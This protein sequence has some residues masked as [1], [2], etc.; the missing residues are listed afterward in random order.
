VRESVREIRRLLKQGRNGRYQLNEYVAFLKNNE[1]VDVTIEEV[2]PGVDASFARRLNYAQLCKVLGKN[3]QAYVVYRRLLKERPRSTEAYVGWVLLASEEDSIKRMLMKDE[4]GKVDFQTLSILC[5]QMNTE[6]E[7]NVDTSLRMMSLLT[8]F[9]KQLEPNESKNVNLSWANYF[10]LRRIKDTSFQDYSLASL[11]GGLD[12]RKLSDKNAEKTA[13]RDRIA[14]HLFISMIR[15]AQ[16]AEQ[17]F[18]LL[19]SSK[20]RLKITEE[21]LR[22]FAKMAAQK[23]FQTDALA[24]HSTHKDQLWHRTGLYEAYGASGPRHSVGPIDYLTSSSLKA[25]SDALDEE[26]L[27]KIE[28]Y[29]PEKFKRMT[30]VKYLNN[31][32]EKEALV[33]FEKWKKSL[34]E[35]VTERQVA[36]HHLMEALILSHP[37]NTAWT[38]ELQKLFVAEDNRNSSSW[39]SIGAKW[40]NWLMLTQGSDVCEDYLEQLLIN[41]LA[42]KEKWPI[43][44]Q[45]GNR[46]LPS[47][48]RQ[49]SYRVQ[50]L[51]DILFADPLV[52]NTAAFKIIDNNLIEVFSNMNSPMRA[53]WRSSHQSPENFIKWLIKNEIIKKRTKGEAFSAGRVFFVW[54][55]CRQVR[56]KDSKMKEAAVKLLR[57]EKSFDPMLAQIMAA[58]FLDSTKGREIIA[59]TIAANP[60]DFAALKVYSKSKTQVMLRDWFPD[61]TADTSTSGAESYLK[62]FRKDSLE[63][64]KLKTAAWMKDGIVNAG[65]S[66]DGS[67][68]IP[69]VLEIIEDDPHKAVTLWTK[70]LSDLKKEESILAGSSFSRPGSS[71]LLHRWHNRLARDISSGRKTKIQPIKQIKFFHHLYHGEVGQYLLEPSANHSSYGYNLWKALEVFSRDQKFEKGKEY[72]GIVMALDAWAKELTEEEQATMVV[73]LQKNLSDRIRVHKSKDRIGFITWVTERYADQSN[74]IALAMQS[75]GLSKTRSN[76]S[77]P[78]EEMKKQKQKAREFFSKL[79]DHEGLSVVMRTDLLY[80]VTYHSYSRDLLASEKEIRFRVSLLARQ[81][82]LCFLYS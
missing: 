41:H 78:E 21:E 26:L 55:G 36:I 29:Q 67:E 32:S 49:Q 70:I 13:D 19:E 1:L 10:I 56:F 33:E 45:L 54:S 23:M 51:F 34:P 5:N 61:M 46:R 44:I 76:A 37:K 77:L 57:A 18:I 17:G 68:Y 64:A 12:S 22:K 73:M 53:I 63:E 71:A 48:Y 66:S 11:L 62:S 27:A 42:P 47:N 4:G 81:K 50:A 30:L 28:K 38:R 60:K 35:S 9:L 15:H 2:N 14:K 65:K 8:K 40:A 31:A 82:F 79:L 20:T 3:D 58:K 52:A 39:E 72:Q 43:L 69:Y 75:F 7:D 59:Q 80:G 16:T 24:E 6:A 25:G 74:P